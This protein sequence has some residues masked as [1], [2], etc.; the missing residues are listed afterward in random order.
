VKLTHE[1][2]DDEAVILLIGFNRPD[3]ILDRLMELDSIENRNVFISIDWHN[4]ETSNAIEATIK[5]YLKR[6]KTNS[7]FDYKIHTANQGLARHITMTITSLLET[8]ESVI[9][10]EDDISINA[11]SI[12][13]FDLGLRF[14]KTNEGIA[15]IGGYSPIGIPSLFHKFN[16]LRESRYFACW[17]WATN[18]TVWNR[19]RLDIQ[20]EDIAESLRGSST[21]ARLNDFQKRTWLGRFHKIQSSNPHTWDFQFQY[22][23]F[24]YSMENLLPLGRITEN[25][26]FMDKRSAHTNDARP[27]WLQVA[28][29]PEFPAS[30]I[31]GGSLLRSILEW[32]ESKST[33]GDNRRQRKSGFFSKRS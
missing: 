2:I 28:P 7:H 1:L 24:R 11:N 14:M 12:A 27:W 4:L 32:V 23:C 33:I 20:Q 10:L 3:F 31:R 26:G 16:F 15:S 25:F 21:W 22:M 9:V 6:K 29:L 17:G 8:Y 30:A 5:N 18:R 19:Y 13:T